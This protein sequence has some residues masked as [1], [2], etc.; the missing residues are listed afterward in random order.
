[1]R[2]ANKTVD[3]GGKTFQ[4]LYVQFV[5]A[6][7]MVQD[8]RLWSSGHRISLIMSE[9]DVTGDGTVFVFTRDRSYIHIYMI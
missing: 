9:L 4:T 3:A 2:L 1:L 8:F 5:S 7:E 6:A